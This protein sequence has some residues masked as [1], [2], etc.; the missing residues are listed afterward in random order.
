MRIQTLVCD[1][2]GTPVGALHVH[3]GVDW[4]VVGGYWTPDGLM[5]VLERHVED[6]AGETVAQ[7]HGSRT[8]G[9]GNTAPGTVV[10]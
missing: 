1:H 8:E 10:A 9:R 4:R 7:P 5:M 3:K 2:Y 6:P